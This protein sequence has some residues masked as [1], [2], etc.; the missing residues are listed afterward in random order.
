MTTK[1]FVFVLAFAASASAQTAKNDYSDPKNWLCLPGRQDACV[2]DQTATIV[3]ADGKL[4]RETWKADP[5]APIDCFYVYPTVSTDPGGNSD[6]VAGPEENGVVRAQFARFASQCRLYAPLYRQATLTALRAAT[7]ASPIAVDLAL[8]YNDVADAWNSYLQRDNNGRGVVLIGH[9]Q[10][11]GVLTQL[12]RNEIDG[13]P[14]Q[15]RLVSAL[16]LGTNLAVPRGKDVGGAFQSI[17]LCRSGKEVGCVIAYA[18]FR[19]T[20]PPPENSRFGRVQGEDMMAACTNPAALGGGRGEL[21][22][23]LAAN[24][25]SIV[26]S[27]SEPR[28]WV[29]PAQPIDSPFVSLPG[30]LT[31]KCV[32]NSKGSYLEVTV[33]GNPLDPR[34]DDIGGDVRTNGQVNASWGLHLIDVQLAMGNL[35]DVVR[36]QARAFGASR[37][38]TGTTRERR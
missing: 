38:G 25:R 33:H 26:G 31:A 32:S 1:S 8:A 7:T 29:T 28:P 2:V 22:A 5:A 14:A 20:V 35:I 24:G 34:T 21:R 9:S 27:G 16:L 37:R 15:S 23:Y 3:A 30:L 36:E 11:S 13:K 17:P 4:S 6:I 12:I 10:G 19:S 18:S